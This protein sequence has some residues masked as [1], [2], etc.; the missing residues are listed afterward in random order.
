MSIEYNKFMTQSPTRRTQVE[1]SKA[2]REKIINAAIKFFAQN[3]FR[4]TKLS[5]IAQAVD[6]SEPGLLHH[7]PSKNH[8][9]ISVLEERDRADRQQYI[10]MV[11][12]EDFDFIPS[13]EGLVKHN[14]TIPG[15][16]KL[17][18]VLVAE[19]ITND[20]PG[21]DFFIKRYQALREFGIELITKSQEKEEIRNDI[22]AEDLVVMIMAMMDGLQIQ[23]LLEPKKI[24]MVKVFDLFMKLL[25]G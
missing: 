5:E 21:H 10:G 23:W 14:E 17:F 9:L 6:M 7:F 24:S 12:G 22:S 4:G 13:I 8:L 19:S 18:T 25:V 20:H 2:S 15:L 3:G 11:D 16:V 1:R